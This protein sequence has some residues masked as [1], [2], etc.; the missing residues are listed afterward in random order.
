ML[1]SILIDVDILPVQGIKA[2]TYLATTEDKQQV[3][4]LLCSLLNTVRSQIRVEELH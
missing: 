1:V 4:T 3:L 2:I